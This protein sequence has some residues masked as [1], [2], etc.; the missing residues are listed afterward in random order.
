MQFVGTNHS[1]LGAILKSKPVTDYSES[2]AF[3]SGH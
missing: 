1:E 2:T 3:F